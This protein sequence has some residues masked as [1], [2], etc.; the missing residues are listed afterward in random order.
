[1]N[2][3]EKYYIGNGKKLFQIEKLINNSDL[4]TEDKVMIIEEYNKIS[5]ANQGMSIQLNKVIE[6]VNNI[7]KQPF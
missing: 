7:T 1:M 3:N 6:A 2:V 5:L 4:T